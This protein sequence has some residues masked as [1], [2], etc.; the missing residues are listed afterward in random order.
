[1][2]R[3]VLLFVLMVSQGCTCLTQFDPNSQPCELNAP[4]GQQCAG[5]FEC[6]VTGPDAGLCKQ[7]ADA[8]Q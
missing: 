8:G 1:M 6:V 7:I 2:K 3:S 5:N 4:P